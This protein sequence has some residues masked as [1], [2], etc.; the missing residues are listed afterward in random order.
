MEKIVM[1][2]MRKFYEG[3]CLTEQEHM[4]EEGNPKVSTALTESGLSVK[5]FEFISI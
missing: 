1:G 2:R 4:V 3:I 5:R